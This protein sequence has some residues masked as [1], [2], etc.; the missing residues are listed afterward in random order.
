VRRIACI[1]LPEIR[2]EVVPVEPHA[3]PGPVAVVV[4][5]PGASVKTE[6]DILG[7]TRLDVVSP[8][9]RAL[10]VKVG[11]TVAAARAKCADLRVRV[12]PEGAVQAALA[13]LAEAALAFGPA[14]AFDVT[15]DVVWVDVGGCAH[16][17]GSERALAQA[18]EAR[19]ESLGHKCRVAVANGP[20][21]SAAVARFA[22][23]RRPGPLVVPA[24]SEAA[25]MR[26]LPVAALALDADTALWLQNLGM[27]KCGDLQKLPRRSFGTRLGARAHDVMQLLDGEDRAPLDPY[28]PPEVPEERVELEWGAS[29][30][31]ALAFVLK[32]LCDRLAARL[33]GRAMGAA[34][35]ELVLSL[36]RSL[37]QGASH[38][39]ALA[40]TL[41]VPLARA[42]DLLAVVRSRLEH[43]TLVAPALQVT[44]RATELSRLQGRTLDLLEP[45]PVADRALPRLVAELSAEL[46]A[47]RVGV[48][49]LVDTW[50]PDARTRLAPFGARPVI[51][52]HALVTSALEPTRLASPR[53]VELQDV[54]LLAPPVRVEGLEWWRRPAQR[55][56]LV[57]A[58]LRAGKESALAWVELGARPHD[59]ALLRGWID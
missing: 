16:L 8:A 45:E 35:L 50:S 57:A 46:G 48:L 55:R 5:R 17:H 24:G 19:V 23:S 29:S 52:R 44:L 12:V 36:D 51:P 41:P 2:L 33:Q 31:E 39:C 49:E 13:R 7:N 38:L 26:G 20:R 25:A 43:H 21:L 1:A 53:P 58:W 14:T 42:A 18:L 15:Q 37:C 11:F 28:R 34:R 4:A 32:T 22:V 40:V 59:A 9:A 3:P 47:D 6:R 27:A 10:G 30:V 56:D 54:T